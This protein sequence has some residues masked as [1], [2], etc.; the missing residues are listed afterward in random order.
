MCCLLAVALLLAGGPPA[1]SAAAADLLPG[2][3]VV[4][5]DVSRGHSIREVT[6]KFPVRVESS[7]L[8]SHGIYL[9]RPTTPPVK[10][11][12]AYLKKLAQDIGKLR[13]VIYAEPDLRVKLDDT[14][15]HAWPY[16][17]PGTS[18][19]SPSVFT[20]QPAVSRLGL[21][22]A[23]THSRG[24][25]MVVAV[26]DTGTDSDHPVLASRLAA[27]WDYVDDD[28][29]PDEAAGTDDAGAEP[30]VGHGTFVSGLVGLAAPGARI[31]PA[32]VLDDQGLGNTFLVAEAVLDTAAAGADVINLSFGTAD[33][34]RSRVLED[35]LKEAR[36]EGVVIVAAAGNDKT[37]A[38]HYPAGFGHVLSVAALRPDGAALAPFATYGTW[39]DVGAI[40]EKL[41]GPVPD[42]G[43][44]TWSGA[45]MASG[46]VS[47]QAA[48]V[49]AARP[50]ATPDQTVTAISHAT[51]PLPKGSVRYGAVDLVE[52]LDPT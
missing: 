13:G 17:P 50:R 35:A 3:I 9:V 20:G 1:P 18:G 11:V 10:N 36:A 39:V 44:A 48:L 52:S 28:A 40:G 34:F 8:A 32:R 43:Y 47:G 19:T 7:V 31:L 23:H 42:G 27:G 30:A 24:D 49:R 5:V 51:N 21:A 14:R 12:D 2:G 29:D 4:K 15:F 37:T 6:A 26:L 16:G 38:P 46:L 41:V 45:S 33:K 22:K 25:G